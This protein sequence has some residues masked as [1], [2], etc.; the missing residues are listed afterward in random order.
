MAVKNG[1][2]RSDANGLRAQ[3]AQN[4]YLGWKNLSPKSKRSGQSRRRSILTIISVVFLIALTFAALRVGSVVSGSD[5]QLQIRI[6][7]QQGATLD[8]RQVQS[9]PISQYLLGTNIFPLVNTNSD[10]GVSKGFMKSYTPFVAS[11]LRAMHVKL[12][13]YPGGTWGEDHIL[14][15]SQL[16]DFSRMLIQ[17]GSDGMLQAH[18]TGPVGGK[19][20]Q[21][22]SSIASGANL[23]GSWVDYMNNSRST[24]RTNSKAPFHPVKFWTVGNE[25]DQ[26]QPNMKKKMTVE[27]YVNI[28]IQYSIAMHQNDRSIK[29]FGPEISQFYGI[30]A[31]PFD[32]K[33]KAWMEG[34]LKGV[35][36]Y[37]KLHTLPFSLLDGVSLHR[38]QFNNTDQ[39]SAML[40]SGSDEWNYLLPPLRSL[41]KQDIGRDLPIGVTEINTNPSQY[42]PPSKGQAALWWADTLGTLMNQQVDYVGF[43]SV[44]AD[45]PRPYPLFDAN[46]TQLTAMGQ[47]MQLFSHLQKNLVPLSLQRDPVSVYA[48]EDDTGQ[49]LS[50]LFINKSYDAQVAQMS[51]AS[52]IPFLKSWPTQDVHLAPNSMVVLT[53]HRGQPDASRAYNLVAQALDQSQSPSLVETVCG[54]SRDPLS[55]YIPC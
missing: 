2:E 45:V 18:I 5:D 41:I 54:H 7:S 6:G 4:A 20:T 47:V 19:P 25:P 44:A 27:Q 48:T 50:L 1:T 3:T 43:F 53:L 14:S 8:L 12:L 29:V 36:D 28:F 15:H 17:T 23:A 22:T 21:L 32:D 40:M 24:Q 10:D 55:P 49:A 52:Q 39:S 51:S 30:G 26:L 37:E 42:T 35:G 46:G 34:F 11:N 33:G 13:R 31:G 38:Y 9:S 16:D